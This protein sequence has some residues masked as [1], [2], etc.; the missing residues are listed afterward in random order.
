MTVLIVGGGI[1]GLTMG[2]TLNQIGVPFQIYE[3]VRQPRPLG[4]GI[5]LQPPSV[6]ELY[7][8]GL[9]S[10]LDQIGVQTRDYGFYTR[11]G[12]EI[13]TEPRGRFAGYNW[14]QYSV[15]RGHLQMAL[16]AALRERCGAD[17]IKFGARARGYERTNGRVKL[18]LELDGDTKSA[19]GDMLIGAD[20]IHSNIRAWMYPHEG[21]P[22]WGG[23]IMWRGTSLAKPFL[24]GASMILAG[25]DTQRFVSYPITEPDR[26]TGLSV[27]N[28]IAER[29][30]DPSTH[31]E[32][33]DWN[34]R[35][36]ISRFASAFDDWKFS[37]IDVPGLI[38]TATEVFEYPMVDREPVN[39]WSDGP[40]TLIGDAAHATYP[41]GSSGASQAILDARILAS[42]FK[43]LASWSAAALSYENRVRPM[44]NKVTLANRGN[45][46]PDAIMQ[47][48]E[49]RCAGDFSRLDEALPMAERAEHAAAFKML[50]GLSVEATNSAGR[51]L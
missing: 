1:A 6:R 23:A 2:L 17:C 25:H 34:R 26:E 49:D 32:K 28:W 41:V 48:A 35:V 18:H 40:V 42:E 4:V 27:I 47:L 10:T 19:T 31:V 38:S 43:K 22:V 51:L 21:A 36:D 3:S 29:T 11:T 45:G 46:G 20:G 8:L 50:A 12:V 37:W 33:E 15:H 30:V 5:N 39:R 24:S 13:W 16:L 9:E 7:A 14:P 44:A